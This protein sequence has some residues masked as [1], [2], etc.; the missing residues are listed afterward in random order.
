ML[1]FTF[2]FFLR[3]DKIY[4]NVGLYAQIVWAKTT[5]IGCG[6][7][8]FQEKPGST[9]SSS[10]FLVCNYGPAGNTDGDP[11]YETLTSDPQCQQKIYSNLMELEERHQEIFSSKFKMLEA[12]YLE[13]LTVKI[14][15]I[16]SVSAVM[17]TAKLRD[18]ELKN[19][20]VLAAKIREIEE[21][22]NNKCSS[23]ENQRLTLGDQKDID[24]SNLRGSSKDQDSVILKKLVINL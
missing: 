8:R 18:L 17:I 5:H 19:S 22:S 23:S 10:T 13:K 24:I 11:F 16:A 6:V 12:R 2:S 21:S 7:T 1:H 20:A 3:S 4:K 14:Q 15:E 9:N